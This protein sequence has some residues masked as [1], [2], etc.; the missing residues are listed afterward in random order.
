MNY[1]VSI[2]VGYSLG[3]INPAYIIGRF[4]GIDI[5]T[6]GS[7]NAGASNAK[8]V[9]GWHWAVLVAIYDISKTMIAVLIIRYLYPDLTDLA[10]LTG[11]MAVLGHIFPFYLGFKGGKGFASYAGLVLI[12]NPL[13]FIVGAVI[14]TIT[15]ITTNWIVTATLVF[16]IS[17]P[18]FRFFT[19][20]GDWLSVFFV[21]MT[22]L[23]IIFKHI[24][25]FK[26]L[27]NHQEIGLNGNY[28]GTKIK[29]E[30]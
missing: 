4:K 20:N 29:A 23:I 18:V 5:R 26:K 11:C 2:L 9:L 3:C 15:T 7:H 21:T 1:L 22:S 19:S 10:V 13:W 17:Y 30:K 14:G 24:P 27:V 6:E 8:I 25:N 28:V 12:L 16:T